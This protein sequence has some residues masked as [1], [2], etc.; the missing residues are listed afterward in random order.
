MLIRSLIGG[1]IGALGL[2]GLPVLAQSSPGPTP[3]EVSIMVED[4]RYEFRT[5]DG[6]ALYVFDQDGPGQSVCN[7][8]CAVAWPPLLSSG[9]SSAVGDW[10]TFKRDDG[11]FQ[12]SYKDKPVYTYIKDKPG[13]ILGEGVG[14]VWHKLL[15]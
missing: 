15:P 2:A 10:A 9:S 4:S 7:D 1:L 6:L 13:T 11:K 8:Q 5:E 14:G 3:V 12:W